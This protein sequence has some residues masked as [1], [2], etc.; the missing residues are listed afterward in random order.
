MADNSVAA[1]TLVQELTALPG[2]VPLRVVSSEELAYF[3]GIMDGEGTFSV[4]KTG[5][6]LAVYN[7]IANVTSTSEELVQWVKERFAGNVCTASPSGNRAKAWQWRLQYKPHLLLL[8]PQLLPF[9]VIK[10]FH[11]RLLLKYCEVFKDARRGAR[12]TAADHELRLAYCTLFAGLN[13]VGSDSAEKKAAVV[14]LFSR[15]EVPLP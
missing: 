7:A 6:G 10:R 5:T 2:R 14:Q 4:Y 9:L 13:A 8:L 3:A 1:D 12:V 11:A 15:G